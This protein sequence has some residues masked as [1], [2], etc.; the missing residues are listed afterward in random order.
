M[1]LWTFLISVA[2]ALL[3]GAVKTFFLKQSYNWKASS[4]SLFI[5]IVRIFVDKVPLALAFPGIHWF[6]RNRLFELSLKNAWSWVIL[7]FSIEFAYYWFHRAS[8][9]VRWLWCTHAVHHSSNEFNLSTNYRVG[10]TAKLTMTMVFFSPIA[11]LGFPPHV[12]ATAFV[13]IL[14]GQFWIH[15]TWIP[16]L[17]PLEW[18][19]NTPSAHR[20]HHAAN[21]E[22]LDANYGATL[23]IFDRIFGTYVSEQDDLPPRYGWVNPIENQNPFIL[24]LTPWTELLR[25]L[26]SAN[27]LGEFVGYLFRPPGWTPRLKDSK[28]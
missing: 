13:I 6:Y 3:E 15:T 5:I 9:R 8:H 11:W 17:G 26:H 20:V 10:W 14:L 24:Q 16:K 2:T 1:A 7:F 19:L 4:S 22:Y 27:N 18:I 23:I 28:D 12:I 21:K 25:D